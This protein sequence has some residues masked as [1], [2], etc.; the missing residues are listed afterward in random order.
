[1]DATK[2][3]P[4]I[5]EFAKGSIVTEELVG[6]RYRE[7]AKKYHPDAGGSV[8]DMQ[9]L[10][11]AKQLALTWIQGERKRQQEFERAKQ[12]AAQHFAA[13]QNVYANAFNQQAMAS[14]QF[15]N[16]M[17]SMLGGLGQATMNNQSSYS[18]SNQPEAS[19]AAPSE[20]KSRLSR[21]IG[22]IRNSYGRR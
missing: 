16:Q 9:Q 12:V 21:F 15:A 6:H 10:N 1:M 17:N 19:P 14:Q 5:L 7:L 4:Q 8:D 11:L 13:A 18:Q 3:W 20:K 2:E 22:G